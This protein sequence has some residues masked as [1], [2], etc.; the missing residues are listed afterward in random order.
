MIYMKLTSSTLV[1]KKDALEDIEVAWACINHLKIKHILLV[2][3][4]N[5]LTRRN[6]NAKEP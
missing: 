2:E 4:K 1:L 3:R 5:H 6:L